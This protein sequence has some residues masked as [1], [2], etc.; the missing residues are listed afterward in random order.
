MANA[1]I[2]LLYMI[3]WYILSTILYV[4]WKYYVEC[5]KDV[6]C[7]GNFYYSCA[8]FLIFGDTDTRQRLAQQMDTCDIKTTSTHWTGGPMNIEVYR[9]V[10]QCSGDDSIK[11]SCCKEH[12]GSLPP[13]PPPTSSSLI[14]TQLLRGNPCSMGTRNCRHPDQW[15]TSSIM[16]IRLNI[17]M[18]TEAMFRNWNGIYISRLTGTD[19][20]FIYGDPTI[21]WKALKHWHQKLETPGP[22]TDQQHHTNQVEYSHKHPNWIQQLKK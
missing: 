21:F 16:Q 2:S 6:C 5:V 10:S 19:L 12:W 17:R 1:S 11:S 22:V 13:A 9:N 20:Q 4:L 7:W 8:L 14:A 3:S 15:P 18:N